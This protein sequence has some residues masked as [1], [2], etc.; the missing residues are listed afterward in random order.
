MDDRSL[1]VAADVAAV[2]S[3]GLSFWLNRFITTPILALFLHDEYNFEHLK[4]KIFFQIWSRDSN[5]LATDWPM[6]CL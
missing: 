2:P 3:S 5:P 6:A 4:F 1:P